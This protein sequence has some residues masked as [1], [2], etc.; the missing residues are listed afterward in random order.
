MAM[1]RFL[2]W[3]FFI[4]GGLGLIIMSFFYT[5][6][7]KDLHLY[8]KHKESLEYKA[9]RVS[10]TNVENDYFFDCFYK[11]FDDY[12][13]YVSLTGTSLG[14]KTAFSFIDEDKKNNKKYIKAENDIRYALNHLKINN[15]AI[16]NSINRFHG[17]KFTYGG[18][19][20]KIKDFLAGGEAFADGILEGLKSPAGIKSLNDS[21]KI[22]M[23]LKELAS[24]ESEYNE[25]KESTALWIEAKVRDLKEKHHVD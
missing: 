11:K 17:F 15:L 23:Y 25:V 10:C 14:L 7:R 5:Q 8:F 12:L 4:F 24:I 19:I 21:A 13:K 9:I 18:Y 16:Q 2:K 20:G 22:K 1:L 6:N 3:I